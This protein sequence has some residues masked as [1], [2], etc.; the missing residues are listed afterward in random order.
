M[1]GGA[2]KVE[3]QKL[4][5][6]H[7]AKEKLLQ[8]LTHKHQKVMRAVCDFPLWQTY[9][10]SGGSPATS[11]LL[12]WTMLTRNMLLPDARRGRT[13]APSQV[14]EEHLSTVATVAALRLELAHEREK[15]AHASEARAA[16]AEELAVLRQRA[17]AVTHGDAEADVRQRKVVIA[18][19]DGLLRTAGGKGE[20][21]GV[22]SLVR[23]NLK[24]E[25]RE[26]RG[27]VP[28]AAAAAR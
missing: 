7:K 15:A 20:L 3:L 13:A 22:I 26:I 1:G 17:G 8:E 6:V 23:D 28:A 14:T 25:V 27:R 18:E 2:S 9:R 19:L 24:R 12:S 4:R 21:A 10:P 5:G 16:P 11:S